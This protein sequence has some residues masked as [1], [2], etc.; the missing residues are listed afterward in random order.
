M[1]G[2]IN[3]LLSIRTIREK[4]QSDDANDFMGHLRSALNGNYYVAEPLRQLLQNFYGD[5][6]GFTYDSQ[7]YVGDSL[8][9]L[10]EALD[11]KDQCSYTTT[12]AR[13]CLSCPYTHSE[14]TTGM[15]Y[16]FDLKSTVQELIQNESTKS[17]DK[18]P[19]CHKE[20][21]HLE[22]VKLTQSKQFLFIGCTRPQGNEQVVYPSPLITTADGEKYTIK[23]V[24]NYYPGATLESG[25]Y[26]TSIYY[27]EQW[28]IARD[29]SS[30]QFN[31]Q[32]MEDFP[33]RGL[34]FIYEREDI[35][36]EQ[37]HNQ[38]NTIDG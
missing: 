19:G 7:Q 37:N 29:N 9:C 35:L 32:P 26:D 11:V 14:T 10:L 5:I 8:D 38:L 1:N 34:F 30:G 25:H 18:C 24:I 16:S 4:I 31:V 3:A 17:V 22:S 15:L 6:Y 36:D 12:M 20:T 23:S 13:S 2:S 28:Y 33:T 21:S 27:N